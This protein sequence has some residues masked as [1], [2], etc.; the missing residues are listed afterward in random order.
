MSAP[1]LNKI[2]GPQIDRT[3]AERSKPPQLPGT[4]L[5][6]LVLG[7][8]LLV[9]FLIHGALLGTVLVAS[10]RPNPMEQVESVT[11]DLVPETALEPEKPPL[12][13]NPQPVPEKK[14][15]PRLEI[16]DFS[17]M[18]TAQQAMQSPPAPAPARP[19]APAANQQPAVPSVASPAS[20][21]APQEKP[22][23]QPQQQPDAGPPPET[24]TSPQDAI[25]AAARI[26]DLMHLPE[27][28]ALGVFDG[29]PSDTKAKLS[30][31]EIAAFRAELRKC[32]NAPSEVPAGQKPKAVI[33]VALKQDG[34]FS[35][36]P[37]LLAVSVPMFGAPVVKNAMQ[38]LSQ[39]QPYHSLPAAKY[40]EWKLLDLEF[41]AQDVA[42][43]NSIADPKASPKR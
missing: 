14:P 2:S 28:T 24:E 29:A 8:A 15:P 34:N 23:Q 4:P 39:C 27:L 35:A 32:W 41:T 1:V 12:P 26:A 11:V 38:A 43:I 21:A 3:V 31:A 5:G 30:A 17:Q 10:P 22:Q 18:L 36:Q 25:A 6:G 19:P 16:P 9:S 37:Q 33:R 20:P 40:A 7:A 42:G 13:E